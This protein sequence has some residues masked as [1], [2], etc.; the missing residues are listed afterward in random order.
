MTAILNLLSARGGGDP[1]FSSVSLLLHMDGSNNGTTFTDSSRFARAIT[2]GGATVTSTTQIQYGTAS[3]YFPA[4]TGSHLSA[5]SSS[6][7]IFGTGDFTV[8]CWL[9]QTARGTAPSI[10]AT[11]VNSAGSGGPN[12]YLDNGYPVFFSFVSN[13]VI[14]TSSVA[15]ALNT[16]TSVA[17]VRAGGTAYIFVNGTQCGSAA[18]SQNFTNGSFPA[19]G[20]YA[21]GTELPFTGYIDEL[22]VTKGVGRYTS[23]YTPFGPFPNSA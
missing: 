5:V 13:A 19:V 4:S 14:I 10:F 16:W 7:F 22:R 1:Y 17:L 15:V 8:E 6:D 21:S 11:S 3:G 20:G 9:Y 2:A 18:N 23:T 12:L